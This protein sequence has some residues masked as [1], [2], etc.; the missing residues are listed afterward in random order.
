[1]NEYNAIFT[2]YQTNKKRDSSVMQSINEY[3][4]PIFRSGA[5]SR[6]AMPTEKKSKLYDTEKVS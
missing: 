3:A 1:M 4:L 6:G 2:L 5:K